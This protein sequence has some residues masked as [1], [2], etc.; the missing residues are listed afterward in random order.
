M[1]LGRDLAETELMWQA[2]NTAGVRT[3]VGLQ[4]R[5]DPGVLHA[6]D[7][8]A[9]GHIGRVLSV[10]LSQVSRAQIACKPKSKTDGRPRSRRQHVDRFTVA[11]NSTW[12][13]RSSGSSARY[14]RA[15][16]PASANG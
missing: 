15:W 2:A 7:L 14:L 12:S 6:R 1:A 11:T 10:E 9:G 13:P 8:I 4:A 16:L 5:N 3:M